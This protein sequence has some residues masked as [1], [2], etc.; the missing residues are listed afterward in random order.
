MHALHTVAIERGKPL[1][2]VLIGAMNTGY[3]SGG[4]GN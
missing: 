4:H 2:D 3:G 1:C